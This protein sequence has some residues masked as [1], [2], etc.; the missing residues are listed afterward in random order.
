MNRFDR[1]TGIKW[2]APMYIPN[3]DK[4][5]QAAEEQGKYYKG[6]QDDFDAITNAAKTA[7]AQVKYI[8]D[9]RVRDA[10]EYKRWLNNL[11]TQQNDISN[12]Y[13]Q[14]YRLGMQKLKEFQ[15]SLH[16]DLTSGEGNYLNSR[17]NKYNQEMAALQEAGQ[18]GG[19]YGGDPEYVNYFTTGK[20]SSWLQDYDFKPGSG[21]LN[22]S[23]PVLQG[24][25]DKNDWENLRKSMGELEATEEDLLTAAG[26]DPKI[27]QLIRE[28]GQRFTNINGKIPFYKLM[29]SGEMKG[30][31][32]DRL[33]PF[34]MAQLT[35]RADD[36]NFTYRVKDGID[37]DV[38]NPNAMF[39]DQPEIDSATGKPRLDSN[40]KP[41][42][43]KVI[44][45]S[46]PLMATIATMAENFAWED[47]T[48]K[49]DMVKNEMA[50]EMWKYSWTRAKEIEDYKAANPLTTSEIVVRNTEEP[51]ITR[52]EIAANVE[53]IAKSVRID[54]KAGDV[55]SQINSRI[56]DALSKL[57]QSP[58]NQE[59]ISTVRGLT[60]AKNNLQNQYSLI[61]Q[62]EKAAG[63][64]PYETFI[65]TV[66]KPKVDDFGNIATEQLIGG[67]KVIGNQMYDSRGKAITFDPSNTQHNRIMQEYQNRMLNEDKEYKRKVAERQIEYHRK[68]NEGLE[69]LKMTYTP[70][71]TFTN[72]TPLE[73]VGIV[74]T[75]KQVEAYN[76]AVAGTLEQHINAHR[77]GLYAVKM[78]GD[79]A[80]LTPQIIPSNASNIRIVRNTPLQYSNNGFV[81]MRG[82]STQLISAVV[83]YDVPVGENKFT[84]VTQP[85]AVPQSVIDK[86]GKTALVDINN[87]SYGFSFSDLNDLPEAKAANAVKMAQSYTGNFAR[88]IAKS[89]DPNGPAVYKKGNNFI[90]FSN[91]KEEV[92]SAQE[93]QQ[94][95]VVIHKYN[96]AYMHLGN[97][98]GTVTKK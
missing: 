96:E 44:N 58:S 8:Q 90:R 43:N 75:P 82:N 30:V 22:I 68:V 17:Y 6:V 54:P 97:N 65:S 92:I 16:R 26:N 60:E 18:K 80:E 89:Y 12:A 28:A 50:S 86:S 39:I 63:I 13:Q 40:G 51:V 76:E 53:N 88:E 71:A 84:K 47:P 95:A 37:Y 24:H 5:T 1:Y 93:A 25:F 85:I 91:G 21:N 32:Q 20:G 52:D 46:N 78:Q 7:S 77:E 98:Q 31:S 62:A 70:T 14:D 9:P 69:R 4:I 49:Y 56:S 66:P 64:A 42:T 72:A 23:S 67:Y 33:M 35:P 2:D 79:G 94:D 45:R 29:V 10:S 87:P 41:I 83:E 3:Y 11:Q 59:L 48:F 19:L 15:Q 55:L 34:L 74:V 27:A 81:D 36:L 57:K 38:M 73:S 61:S